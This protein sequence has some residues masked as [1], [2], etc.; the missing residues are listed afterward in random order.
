MLAVLSSTAPSHPHLDERLQQQFLRQAVFSFL[1]ID[2]WLQHTCTDQATVWHLSVHWVMLVDSCYKGELCLT[3]IDHTTV[4]SHSDD[5]CIKLFVNAASSDLPQFVPLQ[6]ISIIVNNLFI[7]FY[8]HY[9]VCS[10]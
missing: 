3:F 5:V 7:V 9:S 6:A 2:T 1:C 10:V 4:I 8:I